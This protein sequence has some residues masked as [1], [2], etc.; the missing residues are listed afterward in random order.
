MGTAAGK[1]I[2]KEEQEVKHSDAFVLRF[3]LSFSA[4]L[5]L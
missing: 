5:L 3:S 4:I 2:Q 1:K